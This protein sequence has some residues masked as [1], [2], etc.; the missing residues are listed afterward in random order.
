M[1][2]SSILTAL[3]TALA[4]V[5]GIALTLKQEPKSVQATPM[6]Y[7]ELLSID[8]QHDS[9]MGKSPAYLYRFRHRL[10]LLWQ[11]S[12]G[13]EAEVEPFLNAIPEAIH[14]A[15]SLGGAVRGGI[16]FVEEIEPLWVTINSV[17][18]RAM[19]FFSVTLEQPA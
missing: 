11:E 19:D 6:I 15:R 2:Y 3:D 10:L 9:G 1:S 4:G 7:T 8:V 5:S 16:S 12:E 18:Y 13:A 14:T 17:V